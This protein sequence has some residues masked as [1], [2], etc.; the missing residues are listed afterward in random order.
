MIDRSAFLAAIRAEPDN[1]EP[2]LVYA[3]WLEDEGESERAELI[4]LCIRDSQRTWIAA[5]AEKC[6]CQGC[7]DRRRMLILFLE[8]SSL[9]QYPW[10]RCFRRGMFEEAA[11]SW[12]HWQKDAD[13]LLTLEPVQEVRLT[14][15]PVAESRHEPENRR[16]VIRLQG[17]KARFVIMDTE[18]YTIR[19]VPE[20]PPI[21]GLLRAEWPQVKTWVL[22]PAMPPAMPEIP[23]LPNG[24]FAPPWYQSQDN[25]ADLMAE[26]REQAIQSLGVPESVISPGGMDEVGAAI[27]EARGWYHRDRYGTRELSQEEVAQAAVRILRSRS[28]T[29]S[30][31]R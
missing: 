30:A 5:H 8:R 23:R 1:D 2:R 12:E 27:E 28:W 20:F 10:L 22:P 15:R 17:G 14:T 7:V 26:M 18:R 21:S 3:D 25:F 4:R 6:P 31:L 16:T 29:A 19:Q 9:V 13:A 11:C 24:M